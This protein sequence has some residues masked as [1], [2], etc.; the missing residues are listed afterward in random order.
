MVSNATDGINCLA[1]SMKWNEGDIVLLPN[2][3]YP[4]IRKTFNWLREYFNITIVD[5]P[6]SQ[7]DHFYG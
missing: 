2:T 6:L 3:A 1:K 5:V 4:S 7:V